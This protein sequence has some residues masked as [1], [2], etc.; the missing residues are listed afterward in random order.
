MYMVLGWLLLSTQMLWFQI[1]P[2]SQLGED[3]HFILLLDGT[4]L[5]ADNGDYTT[6]NQGG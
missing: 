4:L 1:S 2:I 5:R 6:K 3:E